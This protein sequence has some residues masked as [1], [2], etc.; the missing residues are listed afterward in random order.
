MALFSQP[1]PASGAAEVP[2]PNVLRFARSSAKAE[3]KR[4]AK[5]SCIMRRI[6][7]VTM[8]TITHQ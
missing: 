4:K 3:T 1:S 5:S 6:D 2:C 7:G 8:V